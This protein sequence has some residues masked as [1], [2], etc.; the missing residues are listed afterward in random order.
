MKIKFE[1]D[2][3]KYGGVKVKKYMKNKTKKLVYKNIPEL[4]RAEMKIIKDSL[5]TPS[6][7]AKALETRKVTIAL[8]VETI[9]FFKYQ[10]EKLNLPY[11]RV[12]REL[13]DQYV[14]KSS[15]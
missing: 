5:P 15:K 8:S 9:S 6:M 1:W 4:D 11:Q 2:E 10:A 7:I 14:A 12:V 13:L 3:K